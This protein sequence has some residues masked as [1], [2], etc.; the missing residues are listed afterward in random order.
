M[1]V[2]LLSSAWA[3]GCSS[4]ADRSRSPHGFRIMPAKPWFR[5]GM[6]VRT[7]RVSVSGKLAKV[8]SICFPKLSI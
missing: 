5:V 3:S 4:L 2:T 1:P 7:K 6:P 8:S